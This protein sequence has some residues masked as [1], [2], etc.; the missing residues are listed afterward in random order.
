MTTTATITSDSHNYTATLDGDRVTIERDGIWAG[1][2][3]Y[4]DGQIRECSAD[5][6]DEA[7]DA[8]EQALAAAEA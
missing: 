5:I 2:G 4:Q 1:E 8:L 7:Y 3:L 6:G